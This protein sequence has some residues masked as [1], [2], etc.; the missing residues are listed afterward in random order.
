MDN[1]YEQPSEQL[2]EAGLMV[3]ESIDGKNMVGLTQAGIELADSDDESELAEMCRSFVD[4]SANENREL[5]MNAGL[6]KN[7]AYLK[8]IG[9]PHGLN[10]DQVRTILLSDLTVGDVLEKY[11]GCDHQALAEW[12]E[13][14]FGE[15]LYDI[16]F[17]YVETVY[18]D[19][20]EEVALRFKEH[21][22]RML[23]DYV[24]ADGGAE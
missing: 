15:T 5:K 8:D 6:M 7:D 21:M 9:A 12:V 2:I 23:P 17:Y 10:A 22:E 4:I 24:D 11:S 1:D 16:V 18:G 3:S 13:E 14:E 19:E 20:D